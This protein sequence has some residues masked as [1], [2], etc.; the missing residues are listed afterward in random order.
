M[1]KPNQITYFSPRAIMPKIKSMKNPSIEKFFKFD[2]P[3][4][5][6]KSDVFVKDVCKNKSTQQD[7][8]WFF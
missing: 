5:V 4:E 2:T 8:K 7:I 6:L 3:L 1:I